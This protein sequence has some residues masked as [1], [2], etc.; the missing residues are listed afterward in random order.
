M[1]SEICVNFCLSFI[2]WFILNAKKEEKNKKVLLEN[3]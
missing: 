3:K 1:F 2:G